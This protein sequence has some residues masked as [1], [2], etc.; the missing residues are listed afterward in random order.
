MYLLKIFLYLAG[1]FGDF[2]WLYIEGKRSFQK[3]SDNLSEK[4]HIENLIV[5][6]KVRYL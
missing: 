5:G 3:F 1:P 2:Q 6:I 4:M